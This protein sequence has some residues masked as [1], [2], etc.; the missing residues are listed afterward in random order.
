VLYERLLDRTKHV[1]VWLSYARFEAAPMPVQEGEEEQQRAGESPAERAA[2]SRS[3]YERAFRWVTVHGW[4]L[5]WH[6]RSAD[7]P[8]TLSMQRSCGMSLLQVLL[9]LAFKRPPC[10]RHACCSSRM[11]GAGHQRLLITC[12]H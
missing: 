5:L 7:Y 2:M 9:H 4:L 10:W 3:V 11:A 6:G 8:C 1:K 12:C